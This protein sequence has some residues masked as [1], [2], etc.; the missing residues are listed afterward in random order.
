MLKTFKRGG[1]H[2]DDG[3][4]YAKDKAIETPAIPDQVV[5]PMSQHFGAPCTPTVKV[6][7]HVKKGQL[8]GTSDAF[9]H[10][11]IHASI[12]GDVVKVAPMSHNMMVKCMAVVIKSDGKDEW[13]DGIPQE[14]DWTKLESKEIIELIKKAGV[15][16]C[17]GATFPAHVKF[18]PNKPVDTFIVNGAE[19]EPYLT[20]DYRAMVEDEYVQKLVTGV[21]IIMKALGVHQGYIGIEDN[22]PEA[23]AK[24]TEAF[25]DIPE[26]TVQPCV[27]KY[28]QGAEKMM[29]EAMTG[30]QVEPGGLP[31][32]VGCVVSNVGT[33]IAVTDAVCHGIPFISRLTTV[34]GDCI[35]EPKNL[36][37][38][39]G[40]LFQE[41]IDYCGGFSQ[42]PDRVIGGGPMMGLAQYQLDVPITKGASGILAL[43][44]EKCQVGEESPC[45][46][47]GRC[48]EACPMGL[49]PS[50]LS[51]FSSCQ[52][53]DKCMEYGVMNCV[54]CGSCVY[55]C[56]AKRNIVQYI[57]NAKA[58]CKAMQRAAQAKADAQ[59]A[60]K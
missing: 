7:D 50:Q 47:C 34:T 2:P 56:P 1:V 33:V 15:V 22:K 29:I 18:T 53:W 35:K 52:A 58:Q 6:G 8:I 55:T 59:K 40:T 3:K 30:R 28:P 41:V 12:S 13:A 31:M 25:K 51:I 43:S 20:C 19:C 16:G 24:L 48:V 36:N 5:I 60:K 10:A 23:I 27:T 39:I 4:I 57:R 9:L 21:Q 37:L 17:G 11:D 45:I 26:V 42:T 14:R 54:E 38:R 46:R 32:N 49:I 44:P